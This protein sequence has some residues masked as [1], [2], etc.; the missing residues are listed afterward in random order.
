MCC[1]A[2][3]YSDGVMS[4]AA[5]RPGFS[6][7]FRA[8]MPVGYRQKYTEQAIAA[9]AAIA[10]ARGAEPAG[11]GTFS[12]P[13]ASRT[14]LCVV[15]DDRPGLLAIISAALLRA[16][17]DVTDAEAY[18][19]KNGVASEAVD[20]FW[21]RQA[22]VEQPPELSAEVLAELRQTLIEL[23]DQRE[24]PQ[25]QASPHRSGLTDTRVRFLEGE[26]ND[27]LVLEVETD[28]RSGLLLALAR[29]LYVCGVQIVGSEVKTLGQRVLDRFSVV[30]L[31]GAPIGEDRRLEIQVAVLGAIE[32]G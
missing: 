4:E 25:P 13:E 8:S 15:A 18:T 3:G 17:F 2:M 31:D 11:L 27:P 14:G 21:V 5:L 22:G 19:R 23:L 7:S 32:S 20:I 1:L 6:E 16:G 12:S 24:P 28:D 30:E 10:E 29:A 26:A 9:H